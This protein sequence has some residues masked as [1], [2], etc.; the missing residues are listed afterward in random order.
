MKAF[1]YRCFWLFS[2]PSTYSSFFANINAIQLPRCFYCLCWGA[3]FSHTTNPQNKHIACRAAE[4]FSHCSEP[5][6]ATSE[7]EV[8]GLF[9]LNAK[10]NSSL[11]IINSSSCFITYFSSSACN[12]LLMMC[13]SSFLTLPCNSCSNVVSTS[14]E[15]GFSLALMAWMNRSCSM[16]NSF[17]Q[18]RTS[19]LSSS[20]ASSY[21][22]C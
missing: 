5:K 18:P 3:H 15:S 9:T 8:G 14:A 21:F 6:L 20:I 10:L 11:S 16:A 2:C 19:S 4:H 1:K 7:A 12:S 13:H 22:L 17:A